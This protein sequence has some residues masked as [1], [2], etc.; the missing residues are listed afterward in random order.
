MSIT[1]YARELLT[2]RNVARHMAKVVAT[3]NQ[4]E[5]KKEHVFFLHYDVTMRLAFD[6]LNIKTCHPVRYL[7]YI[8]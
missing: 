7:F 3:A 5:K 6:F 1:A 2:T 8:E 4:K